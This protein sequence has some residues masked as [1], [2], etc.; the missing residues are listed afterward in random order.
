MV[1]KPW[2]CC[3]SPVLHLCPSN[4]VERKRNI[5]WVVQ[6]LLFEIFLAAHVFSHDAGLHLIISLL[7]P[8]VSR[9][10]QLLVSM[11]AS[12]DHDWS[13]HTSSAAGWVKVAWAE[14]IPSAV[15]ICAVFFTTCSRCIGEKVMW[16]GL[17]RPS[18]QGQ[19]QR[20]PGFP[21][22]GALIAA[23]RKLLTLS[24]CQKKHLIKFSLGLSPSIFATIHVALQ[25]CLWSCERF[26][27]KQHFNCCFMS[28]VCK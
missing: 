1:G 23:Y 7:S 10:N 20:S 2:R 21:T 5:P 3:K 16:P 12:I 6:K 27:M 4:M 18:H 11:C 9:I 25:S 15:W 26:M 17:L 14:G 19:R 28:G 13:T 22:C 8:A 24:P